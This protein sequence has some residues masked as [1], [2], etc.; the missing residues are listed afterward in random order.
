MV[1]YKKSTKYKKGGNGGMEHKEICKT[2]R[3]K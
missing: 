2:Y 3:D 1:H